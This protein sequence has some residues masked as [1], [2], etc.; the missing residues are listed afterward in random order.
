MIENYPRLY[1]YLASETLMG[2]NIATGSNFVE[3][4]PKIKVLLLKSLLLTK[5]Q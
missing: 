3:W 1:K 5:I 2:V 4:I